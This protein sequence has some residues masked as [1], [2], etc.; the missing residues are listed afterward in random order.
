MLVVRIPNR[1]TFV[2]SFTSKDLQDIFEMREALEGMAARLAA[3]RRKDE[4]LE[5]MI[6]LFAKHEET[7]TDNLAEKIKISEQLHQFVLKSCENSKICDAIDPLRVHIMR[8]W[9]G[10][11]I[12]P[13]RI[14]RAFREHIEI[15]Q[16]L[17]EKNEDIAERRMKEHIVGAFRDYI[18]TTILNE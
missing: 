15:L 14:N 3:R 6:A 17:K 9:K 10:G 18:K 4:A 12:I 11:L 5:E 1:G 2:K 16:A 8:T 7:A 13:D